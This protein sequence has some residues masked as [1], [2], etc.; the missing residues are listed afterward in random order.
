MSGSTG[1]SSARA[2]F[3]MAKADSRRLAFVL[4]ALVLGLAWTYVSALIG[5]GAV[6]AYFIVAIEYGLYLVYLTRSRDPVFARLLLIGLIAGGLELATDAWL[7]DGTGTLV[8][9]PD[10]P[11]LWRSPLYMPVAWG[12]TIL[13]L[14]TIAHWASQRWPLPGCRR[15]A[16]ASSSLPLACWP[17]ARPARPGVRRFSGAG[18]GSPTSAASS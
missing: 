6:T 14:G 12:S 7:V 9:P 5:A 11:F 13:Q 8:Y 16:P 3:S 17:P 10:G 15:S 18:A 1:A 2:S 4:L